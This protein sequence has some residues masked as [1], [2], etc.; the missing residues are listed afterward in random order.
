[1]KTTHSVWSEIATQKWLIFIVACA[2]LLRVWQ[3]N[4]HLIFFGDAAHDIFVAKNAIA[5]HTL[6]LLGIQSSVPRFRQGPLAIWFEMIGLF[7]SNNNLTFVGYLFALLSVGAILVTYELVTVN[8]SQRAALFTTVVL[9]FSPLAVANARTPYHTTPIPLFVGLY[10][11]CVMLLYHKKKHA[12]FWSALTFCFMF[13]FELALTPLVLLIPYVCWRNDTL[14]KQRWISVIPAFLLG[15]APQIIYDLTHRFA[16]LGGFTLWI[17]YRIA[18]FFGYRHDHTFS[19]T[20]LRGTFNTFALYFGRIW[21]AENLWLS[22]LC[23]AIFLSSF[24]LIIWLHQHHQK[25]PILIEVA[26][27]STALLFLADIVLGSA[28]EAY[29]PPFFVLSAI[30]IGFVAEYVWQFSQIQVI[31]FLVLY[32]GINTFGI[33]QHNFFVST[34]APFSYGPS[35]DEQ[36]QVVRTIA[37]LSN[38]QFQFATARDDGKFPSF[39]DNLRW[40]AQERGLAENV[41]HGQIFFIE[42][43]TSALQTY[44]SITRL[45][46]PT[47]DVYVQ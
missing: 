28:S 3:L 45:I 47:L 25:I 38:N 37:Q 35:I 43:K 22:L 6:P 13:Q 42:D 39:F 19:P 9:A 21:S 23:A 32:A 2:T 24:I 30:L 17:L 36:R 41:Q 4:T 11:W 14:K 33:F 26:A 15:L 29:F 46:F 40:V 1:M 31:L 16:Q 44:P 20:L 18:A 5:S 27:L 8:Y 7:V 10:L 34:S 12:L